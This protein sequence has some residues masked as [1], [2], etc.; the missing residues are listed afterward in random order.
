MKQM[1]IGLASGIGTVLLGF[2]AI[3][4]LF[5]IFRKAEALFSHVK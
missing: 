2:S 1:I 3:G 5:W 4:V